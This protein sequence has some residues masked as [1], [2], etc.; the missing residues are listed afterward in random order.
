MNSLQVKIG[1]MSCSFCAESIRKALGRQPGV[2]E[3]HV[4]LAHEEALVRF[5]PEATSETRIKDTLR[6]LGYSLRDLFRRDP[7]RTIRRSS[8]TASRC[9]ASAPRSVTAGR[10]RQR[11]RRRKWC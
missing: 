5:R 3:V 8:M 4:S 7:W 11:V 6:A 2:E 10:T 9:C 1:G